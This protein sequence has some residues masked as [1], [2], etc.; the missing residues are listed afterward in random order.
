MVLEVQ[1]GR[2]EDT[3]SISGGEGIYRTPL[4]VLLLQH[5]KVNVLR[6]WRHEWTKSLAGAAATGAHPPGVIAR[7]ADVPWMHSLPE[8]CG[9]PQ[10]G[11]SN[12]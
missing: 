4:C 12:L 5:G 1:G 9:F 7:G 3:R 2:C 11:L 8:Y 10:S 6:C